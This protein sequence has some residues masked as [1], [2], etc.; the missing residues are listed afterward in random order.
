MARF[1]LLIWVNS[2]R[3]DN[4]L[5]CLHST[6]KSIILFSKAKIVYSLKCATNIICFVSLLNGWDKRTK[7]YFVLPWDQLFRGSMDRSASCRLCTSLGCRTRGTRGRRT[8]LNN[9]SINQ[10]IN[11]PLCPQSYIKTLWTRCFMVECSLLSDAS[12]TAHNQLK[13]NDD[14]PVVNTNYEMLSQVESSD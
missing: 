6:A 3:M 7:I 4:F 14:H 13:S 2:E 5:G 10:S 8:I 12:P 9:Q 11:Q 1:L